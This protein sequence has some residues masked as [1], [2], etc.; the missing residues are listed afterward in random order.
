MTS[1]IARRPRA[2]AED[3][4]RRDCF[5]P[6]QVLTR[7]RSGREVVQDFVPLADSLE[8]ECMLPPLSHSVV[9]CSE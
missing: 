2:G 4:S 8:W 7:A 3:G 1:T 9:R 6:E 5:P